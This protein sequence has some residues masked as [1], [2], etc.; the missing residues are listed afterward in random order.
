MEQ[1]VEC[2]P[3][4]KAYTLKVSQTLIECFIGKDGNPEVITT[5]HEARTSH[6]RI[7]S[8]IQA[9][10]DLLKNES[11]LKLAKVANFLLK[12]EHYSVITHPEKYKETYQNDIKV[13]EEMFELPANAISGYGVFNVNEIQL[14]RLEEDAFIFYVSKTIPYRVTIARPFDE[15]TVVK[16]ELL[17]Y[18]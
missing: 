14:P 1:Q 11:L 16:Y 12:G 15:N 10:P 4:H 6:Q 8:L 13:E 7:E 17:S 9:V 5:E 2:P 3:P 18:K